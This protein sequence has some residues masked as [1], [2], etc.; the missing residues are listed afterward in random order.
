MQP[1]KISLMLHVYAK[2]NA[3]WAESRGGKPMI[4]AGA[5]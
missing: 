2:G 4:Y 3:Q 5:E 1:V